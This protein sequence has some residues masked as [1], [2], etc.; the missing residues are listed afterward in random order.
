[1]KTVKTI[2][3]AMDF[4]LENSAGSVICVNANGEEKEC[5]TFPE[6]KEFMAENG[7][8]KFFSES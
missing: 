7:T 8:G 2:E 6:A 4:F 1:M 3:E 5:I